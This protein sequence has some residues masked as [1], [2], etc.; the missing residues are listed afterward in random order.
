[1]RT[2]LV[3]LATALVAASLAAAGC[4]GSSGGSE[5]QPS[6]GGTPVAA[7]TTEHDC[8]ALRSVVSDLQLADATGWGFEY[9]KHRDFLDAYADRAPDEVADSVDRLRDIVG[10]YADA[11]QDAGLKPGDDPLPDQLD[12]LRDAFDYS[13]VDQAANARAVQTVDT[14]GSNG[15]GS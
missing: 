1:M 8:T 15:C 10:R 6:A 4:G 13:E 12:D 2:P 9:D 14:W 5:A 3:I 11:A 7:R